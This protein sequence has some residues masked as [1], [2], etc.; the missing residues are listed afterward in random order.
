MILVDTSVVVEFLRTDDPE[1]RRV[2]VAHDA[3]IC[4]VTRAEVLHGA[5]RHEDIQRLVAG[6]NVFRNLPIPETLW[7]RIGENLAT[8]RFAGLV[9]PF[10]DAIL[11]TVAI[12]YGL[13]L[14]TRDVHFTNIQQALP[15]LMLF[16]ESP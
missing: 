10:A 3:A 15:G 7:D 12:H 14:W 5:R 8:L 11:A 6:L 4:G 2:F 16:Q 9:V 1:M 13:Q